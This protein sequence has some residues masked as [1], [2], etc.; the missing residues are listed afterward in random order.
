M[1]V[2]SLIISLKIAW[3]TFSLRVDNV[4]IPTIFTKEPF[5]LSNADFPSH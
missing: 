3:H 5:I 2:F 4:E 1:N